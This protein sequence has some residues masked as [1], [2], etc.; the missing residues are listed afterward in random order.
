MRRRASP[1]SAPCRP[2]RSA[3]HC[4]SLVILTVLWAVWRRPDRLTITRRTGRHRPGLL[5]RADPRPRALRVPVLRA[6][7]DP[8]RGLVALADRLPRPGRRDVRQHVR[9]PDDDLPA[10]RPVDEPGP[11]LAGIGSA[12]RS[13]DRRDRHGGDAHGGGRMGW[14]QLRPSGRERLEEELYAAAREEPRGGRDGRRIPSARS[15]H[16]RPAVARHRRAGPVAGSGVRCAASPTTLPTWSEPARFERRR[17]DRLGRRPLAGHAV[18][19]GSQR[20]AQHGGRR[21]L[22]PPRCLDH[23]RAHPRDPGDPHVPARRAVPDALRRGLSRADRDRVPAGLAIRRV[24]RHLR[25]DPPAPR[26]VRD[27]RRSRAVGRRPRQGD[28]RAW[29]PGPRGRRSSHAATRGPGRAGERLHI[30]TGTEIRTEDLRTRQTVGTVPAPASAPWRST[31]PQ[32]RLVLGSDDGVIS[33]LDLTTVAADGARC[34][35]SWRPF[36][37]PSTI[38]SSPTMATIV[39]ASELDVTTLDGTTGDVLGTAEFEGVADLAPGGS[40]PVLQG[41]PAAMEDPGAVAE[42]ARRADRR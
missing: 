38:C 32:E 14:L 34:S 9:R 6:R 7:G 16:G 41:D 5:R 20:D 37:T 26:Q 2:S 36:R 12:I 18:P 25:M 31:R 1:S 33:T 28:C 40:G 24:T 29:R 17:R 30:A 35:T 42:A 39:A 13:A 15:R 8:V 4:W 27:G 3:R 10:R 19:C 21:P 22:R 11:R 23:G